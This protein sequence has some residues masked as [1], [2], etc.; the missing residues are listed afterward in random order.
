MGITNEILTI[1][2][3]SMMNKYSCGH[4]AIKAF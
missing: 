4:G 1:K 3:N 2:T